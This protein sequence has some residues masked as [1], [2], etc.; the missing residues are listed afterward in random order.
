MSQTE[1]KAA[2]R[3]FADS[4]ADILVATDVASR[5]LDLPDVTHVY[6][7]DLPTSAAVYVHRAGRTARAGAKGVVISIVEGADLE[8]LQAIE[9]YTDRTVERRTIKG[10]CEDFPKD[11]EFKLSTQK[12]GRASIG[13]KG[14]F[15]RKRKD[16]EEKKPKVKKRWRVTKNI[17]KPDFAA[18]RAKKAARL[19]K[20]EAQTKED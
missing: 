10:I 4:S 1:R 20:K 13:G 18:K 9:R 14:G 11:V 12:R 7:Y 19:A 3:R 6:N 16:E 5:G 17:G 2:L 8:K 15:D